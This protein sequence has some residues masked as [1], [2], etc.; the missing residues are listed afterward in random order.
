MGLTPSHRMASFSRPLGLEVDDARS[1]LQTV[2][3]AILCLCIMGVIC[4]LTTRSLHKI[5][6][7][8]APVNS[9]DVP[10]HA[11]LSLRAD[12]FSVLASVGI[13]IALLVLTPN[14]QSAT[15][16]F[17]NVTD[18]SGWGSK[19]FSFLLGYVATPLFVVSKAY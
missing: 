6:L 17:T 7:W 9:M 1:A 15:W 2:L 10:S 11:F 3:L 14:K 13:C 12:V 16:V 19:G 5:I 8:F 18:G 4:S